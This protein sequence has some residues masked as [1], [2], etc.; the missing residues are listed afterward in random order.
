MKLLKIE[1]EN[2][3][4][5]KSRKFEFPNGASASIYGDN[6]TGKTTVYNAMTWLLFDKASTGVKG[7]SP[8]T[9]GA[10]GDEVHHIENSVSATFQA[11]SG[12]EVELRKTSKEIY[13]KKRGSRKE[14]YTGNTIDYSINGVPV[15]QAEYNATVLDL[16][17][18]DA[19]KTK[20]LT[21]PYYFPEVIPWES[22]RKILLE[23]CGD[24]PDEAVIRSSSELSQ[25]P[26]FLTMPGTGQSYTVDEYKKIA[27]ARRRDLGKKL[28]SIPVLISEAYRAIPDIEGLTEKDVNDGISNLQNQIVRLNEERTRVSAPGAA[29][30]KIQKAI[31]EAE[32]ELEKGRIAHQLEEG[33]KRVAEQERMAKDRD[34]ARKHLRA[35][36]DAEA[37][38]K[39][40]KERVAAMEKRR[41]ELAAEWNLVYREKWDESSETCPTC[42]QPFP[43]DKVNEMKSDF[44]LRKS[45]KLSEINETGKKEASKE[46]IAE[47]KR[48]IDRLESVLRTETELFEQSDAKA[49]A[50]L[51]SLGDSVPYEDTD[52]YKE[53]AETI[54]LL[55]SQG[56]AESAMANGSVE[57]VDRDIRKATEQLQAAMANKT[58]LE[59]A[60]RQQ[61]RI[62]ELAAQ[63]KEL[64][65]EYEKTEHGL[66]LCECFVRNKVNMLTS[67]IN[68]KFK[69]VRFQLFEEQNT[70]GIKEM[71]DVLVPS[72]DGSMVPFSTAN[73]AARINAGLEIIAT[74]SEHA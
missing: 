49:M 42:G 71:C 72:P 60:N 36:E 23:I 48:E 50:R 19:E 15:K 5:T 74:L 39:R 41:N 26:D 56:E 9:R 27:T 63:E 31:S 20:I 38:L 54:S 3:Q 73:N 53:I 69:S 24:I 6:A 18:G 55:K 25:L 46:M 29:S 1:M 32:A 57:L 33:R 51:S 2:F 4:G 11:E 10:D 28:E 16:C 45:K 17:G 35:K 13:R 14:E 70:G 62:D 67:S 12:K 47:L 65:A 64:S 40:A 22:R 52:G 34:E 66:Y 8:K 21:M 68:Q 30:S 7:F 61:Q 43:P 59:V 44:N 37:E 58:M